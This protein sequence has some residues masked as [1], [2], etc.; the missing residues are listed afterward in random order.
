MVAGPFE[1]LFVKI[2]FRRAE[3]MP[4]F[5]PAVCVAVSTDPGAELGLR[6]YLLDEG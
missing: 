2:K 3:S 5:F 6:K 4:V 1:K